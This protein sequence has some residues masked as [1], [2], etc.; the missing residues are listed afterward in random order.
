M[1]SLK[2]LL[3]AGVVV[4]LAT[5]PISNA[6][7]RSVGMSLVAQVVRT[8]APFLGFGGFQI[9]KAT[10]EI[11]ATWKT[12]LIWRESKAGSA[13][14]W[15][16]VQGPH[17]VFLQVGTTEEQAAFGGDLYQVFWSDTSLNDTPQPLGEIPASDEVSA[18]LKQHG[19]FWQ[20]IVRD[21]AGAIHINRRIEYG[22]EVRCNVGEW[23]Q[24][25]VSSAVT[26]M[27]TI[28]YPTMSSPRFGRLTLNGQTPK[29]T[30][31]DGLVLETAAGQY[32]VPSRYQGGGFRLGV[33]SADQK[34]VLRAQTI[35]SDGAAPFGEQLTHW[36][37]LTP[38]ERIVAARAYAKALRKSESVLA[39]GVLDSRVRSSLGAY[40]AISAAEVSGL[41]RWTGSLSEESKLAKG[42][43]LVDELR[44]QSEMNV[45]RELASLPPV[46]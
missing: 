38:R 16:G 28:P 4:L 14:T 6:W 5:V 37:E 13:A 34:A 18:V 26:G 32:R 2:G 17:G 1:R 12:P 31:S 30:L 25:S 43:W 22:G 9:S 40:L 8:E 35:V 15:I 7:S 42:S 29:L 45:V 3:I 46:A 39:A 41:D 10:S 11:G 21:R 24:E 20:V 19:L 33:P 27:P 36:T 44:R 23:I